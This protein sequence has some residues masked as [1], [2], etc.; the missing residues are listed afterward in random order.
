M[1]G[2]CGKTHF[3]HLEGARLQARRNAFDLN[4]GGAESPAPSKPSVHG[5]NCF[6]SLFQS[7]GKALPEALSA[8][9]S[10]NRTHS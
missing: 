3:L 9:L 7:W 10:D 5:E 6:R 4:N 2:C 1:T 8:S